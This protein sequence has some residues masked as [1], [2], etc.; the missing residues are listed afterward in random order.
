MKWWIADFWDFYLVNFLLC[1]MKT[2][3]ARP[4]KVN[5]VKTGQGYVYLLNNWFFI[6]SITGISLKIPVCIK[7]YANLDHQQLWCAAALEWIVVEP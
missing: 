6:E 5:S 3:K 1:E 4:Q 2:K 7:N